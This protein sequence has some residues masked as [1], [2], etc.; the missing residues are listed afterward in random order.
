MLAKNPFV[1][2]PIEEEE[3]EH[4]DYIYQKAELEFEDGQKKK[5]SKNKKT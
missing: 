3:K 2:V 4:Q 1:A 5:P